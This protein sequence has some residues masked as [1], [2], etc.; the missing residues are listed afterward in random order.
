MRHLTVTRE[1][2][3][4]A[5]VVWRLLSELDRWPE[6]GPSVRRVRSDAARVAPGVEGS[7]ELPGGWTLPFRIT[8]VAEGESWAWR[9]AGVQATGHRVVD[10][11]PD[12]CR[13]ELSVPV[14]LFPY[15]LILRVALGR[16]AAIA[17]ESGRYSKARAASRRRSASCHDSR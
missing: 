8:R 11:G 14:V 6:W 10:L 15:A 17:T 5:A 13:A 4:P 9:V 1:I 16:L 2:G 3:A 7:V 12:R